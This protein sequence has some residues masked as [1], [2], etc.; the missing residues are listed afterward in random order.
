MFTFLFLLTENVYNKPFYNEVVINKKSRLL[1]C[2]TMTS[3]WD[4]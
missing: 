2:Q 3:D 4:G 1:L